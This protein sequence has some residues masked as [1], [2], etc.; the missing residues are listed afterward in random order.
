MTESASIISQFSSL[1]LTTTEALAYVYE[2]TLISKETRSALGTHSTPSFLVDYV[3]G[4]LADW[5]NEIPVNERNVYE[6]ACGHA[7]FLVSA[8]RLLTE[9][10]PSE[11]AVPSRRGPYL[12]GRLHGTDIDS[13]ALELAR[14]SLTLTDI[15]NPD[16][17]DLEPQNMF[18]DGRLAEQARANTILLA[19]P[20]F[21]DFTPEEKQ[22]YRE[23]KS[24]VRFLNK[25]AEML[26]RT[27][28]QLREGS[29]FGVILPQNF[30][31]SDN[32]R[33]IREFLV[34][35][36][37]L[38]EIC[39][40]PDQVFSFSDAESACLIG[41]RKKITRPPEVRYRRIREREVPSFRTDYLASSTRSIAQSGSQMTIRFPF[42]FRPRGR[43]EC[44][45]G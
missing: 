4:N 7:A 14:L 35:E 1:V 45:G 26:W 22:F 37:E 43:L 23:K 5:I 34:R 9:L 30:L 42:A 3:V 11:K 31:H 36:C 10:L 29:V 17:W 28:P 33:E 44:F 40:F 32:G 16:G 25:S 38:K 15:P 2:N 12:R 18:L 24:E 20:P 19:N 8:M 41:A 13:F 6:P 21:G 39:L 27:L